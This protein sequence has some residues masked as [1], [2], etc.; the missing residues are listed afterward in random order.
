[1]APE[2]HHCL[3]FMSLSFALGG[4]KLEPKAYYFYYF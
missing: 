2:E 3:N 1:M 4:I